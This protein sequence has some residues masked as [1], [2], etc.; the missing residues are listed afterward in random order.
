M[1]RTITEWATSQLAEKLD[2]LELCE[3]VSSSW[4]AGGSVRGEVSMELLH[5][6]DASAPSSTCT[7]LAC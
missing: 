4:D 6:E 7:P 3:G 2:S 1:A 5:R